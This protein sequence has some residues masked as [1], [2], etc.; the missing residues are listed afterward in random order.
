MVLEIRKFAQDRLHLPAEGQFL[1]YADHG[2]PAAVWNVY[3][4]PEFSMVPKTWC[5]PI[6]GCTV[7]KGFFNAQKALE[8][9]EQLK[10]EGKDVY[11][12]TAGGYSTLGWFSDPIFKNILDRGNVGMAAYIFHELAHKVVFIKNDTH[13]NEGFAVAVE[14]EG[15]RRWLESRNESERFEQYVQRQTQRIEFSYLV[16]NT[17]SG[18]SKLYAT[19]EIAPPE[20]KYQKERMFEQMQTKYQILKSNWNG[21]GGYDGWFNKPLNNARL[22][23]FG[24]YYDH[25]PA[26][27]NMIRATGGDLKKFFD[28]VEI[29]SRKPRAERNRILKDYGSMTIADK[30]NPES[31]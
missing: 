22:I 31:T 17:R 18:L 24:A 20:K 19:P 12:S 4:A 1:Y 25:V 14:Q 2:R 8:L 28:Y 29:L 5:F 11:V 10:L 6:V 13:F 3:T 30:T 16:Q 7:Y 21:Y 26:F 9:A 23:P 15:V 27:T